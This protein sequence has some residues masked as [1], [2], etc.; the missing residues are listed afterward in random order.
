MTFVARSAPRFCT[1]I[2][3]VTSSPTFGAG[4]LTVFVTWRSAYC[5]VSVTE[6]E[7]LVGSGSYWSAFWMEAVLVRAGG[8]PEAGASTR[9]WIE[10]VAAAATFTVPIVQTPVPWS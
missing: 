1:T 9:A 7:S 2:R 6:A 10:S 5:G 8:M 4:S 3:N